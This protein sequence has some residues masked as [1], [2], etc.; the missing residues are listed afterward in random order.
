MAFNNVLQLDSETLFYIKD[1]N[2]E[3]KIKGV[4]DSAGMIEFINNDDKGV[5]N[6]FS[7]GRG[8]ISKEK[9]KHLCVAWLAL[10]YPETL[11]FYDA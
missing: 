3:K 4:G 8:E 5:L 7:D 1:E 10:N 6:V 11:K 9:F 2:S